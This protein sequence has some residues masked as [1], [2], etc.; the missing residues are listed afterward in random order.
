MNKA[1][2][3]VF[4]FEFLR[5]AKKPAFWVAALLIPIFIV[6]FYLIIFLTTAN[7]TE[8]AKVS[9]DTKIAITD[10]AGVFSSDYP[11]LVKG[12]KEEGIEMV[13]D[14][15]TDL[16]FYIPKDFLETKRVEFYHISEG[17]EIFNNDG[18][19]IRMLM[20]EDASKRIDDLDTL[21]LTKTY[22]VHDNKLNHDGTESNAVGKAIVPF[23]IGVVFFLFVALCGN[24]F[25]MIVV[26]EKENRISE[27]ILTTVSSKHLV[28]GKM[29]AMLALGAIQIAVIV[30]PVFVLVFL[31][32]DNPLISSI[33]S[34]IELD[35]LT[36]VMSIILFIAS[37]LFYSGGCTLIG[38]MVPTAREASSFI[39]PAIVLMVLP[40]YFMQ[41]F[42]MTEPN[43]MVQIMTYFPI[44]A[45]IALVLRSGF[46]TI[47]MPEYCIGIA[48]VIVFSVLAIYYA[49][50]TFQKN[51]IN[52]SVAVPKI[53]KRK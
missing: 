23:F 50:K 45:P 48:I 28:I 3:K 8:E 36:I 6:G 46:G 31:N 52:F 15:D 12:D 7:N 37:V 19:I 38:S 17:M 14:G 47:T 25:L 35:P 16:Y 27:M 10:E 20:A 34:I 29:L 4:K 32:R 13:K 22:E 26:E 44:T 18:E 24:R 5:Q 53:L 11:L 2:S 21:A 51:A 33:L 40:L 49:I 9:D 39:G 30:V 42:M 41:M 1:I 43:M